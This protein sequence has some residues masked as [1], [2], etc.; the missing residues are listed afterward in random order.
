MN[1]DKLFAWVV[2]VVLVFAASGRLEIL[3]NWI[4]RAQAKV[5]YESRAATWG[6]PRFFKEKPSS[7]VAQTA[8]KQNP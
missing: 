4:W 7:S 2:G 5:V 1:L 6:S 8:S 3:Q